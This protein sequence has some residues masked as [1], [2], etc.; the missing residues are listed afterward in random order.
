MHIITEENAQK[1]SEWLKT[2]GGVALWRSVDLSRPGQT[3]WAPV[4]D[5]SGTPKGKPHW[6]YANEPELTVNDPGEFTVSID[7]EVKRFHVAVRRGGNGFSLKLTDASSERVRK[8]CEKAGEGAYYLFDY[9]D[10]NNCVILAPDKQIPL[11]EWQS[12]AA[13]VK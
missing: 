12:C 11:T 1:I 4:N 2:R 3:A 8:A 9:E 10:Y 13:A 6:M 7:K 5:E